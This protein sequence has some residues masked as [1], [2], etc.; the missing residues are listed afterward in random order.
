M[1]PKN[2]YRKNSRLLASISREII[3]YFSLDFDAF[4]TSKILEWKVSYRTVKDWYIYLREE[5]IYNHSKIKD[6][7]IF[8]E[9]IY[10]I[11]E[12]YFWP[13]RIRWKRWRWA[14][15]KIKV[16]WILKR[17]N[18]VYT[19]IIP[20]CTAKT[21]LPVI[22]WKLSKEEI[23]KITINSDWWKAYDWLV[24]LWLQK[25]YR[26]HHWDNEFAR[27]KQHINWIESFWS[28][29]KRRLIKFNWIREDKFIYHLKESEF[30]FNCRLQNK[31]IY[32]ELLKLSKQYTKNKKD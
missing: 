27:W 2:P 7:E 28:F 22:R 30:R 17:D 26:I 5:V 19:K 31:D 21:L 24:D 8:W 20:D 11:D 25:H 14:W 18:Q 4:K 1:K 15:N 32:K 9:W 13:K 12:S 16:F 23:D 3:K 29:M 6:K 10:E